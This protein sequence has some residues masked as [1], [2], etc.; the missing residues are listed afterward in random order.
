MLRNSK[1][2]PRGGKNRGTMRYRPNGLRASDPPMTD[3]QRS[4][5]GCRVQRPDQLWAMV[6][7]D[8]VRCDQLDVEDWIEIEQAAESR[9]FFE[10][11]IQL[12]TENAAL[13]AEIE[14]L[15]AKNAVLK[16]QQSSPPAPQSLNETGYRD[17]VTISMATIQLRKI[18]NFFRRTR[19][20]F[21]LLDNFN[22]IIKNLCNFDSDEVEIEGCGS[23]LRKIFE[24]VMS[25]SAAE[26]SENSLTI[27]DL[28]FKF[29]GSR[30]EFE[31]FAE[32]VSLWIT[33]NKLNIPDTHFIIGVM[34]RFTARKTMLNGGIAEYEK[35]TIQVIDSAKK[36]VFMI[37][38]T[39]FDGSTV[40]PCDFTVNSFAVSP[41][42]GIFVKDPSPIR[43]NAKSD[44]LAVLR[45][46]NSRTTACMTRRNEWNYGDFSLN[47][48][49]RGFK[50]HQAGYQM[51]GSPILE[52]S[53]CPITL[54]ESLC[55][56]LTGCNCS[57]QKDKN[58]KPIPMQIVLSISNAIGIYD[59]RKRCPH[60]RGQ[61]ASFISL[62]EK[63][64]QELKDPLGFSKLLM[65]DP[66]QR[67]SKSELDLLKERAEKMS[68]GYK[69]TQFKDLS[70]ESEE[71]LK[72]LAQFSRRFM[73]AEERDEIERPLASQAIGGGG[74]DAPPL[75][76]QAIG[77]GGASA[78]ALASQAR[79]SGGADAPPLASQAIGGGGAS[80]PALA[81]QARGSGGASAPA[82][83]S[84]ARGSG[85]AQSLSSFLPVRSISS[86]APVRPG[87]GSSIRP[88][89]RNIPDDYPVWHSVILRGS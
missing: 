39:L 53:E 27:P 49:L 46:V 66:Q 2:P 89:P 82:L 28:D 16:S 36:E 22:Q 59:N 40:F 48:L 57:K 21:L 73:S 55:V 72:S 1:N 38:I 9:R 35:F 77:G 86:A 71:V 37:D 51:L 15:K 23:V 24:I 43:R 12:K 81:S 88:P 84:Q 80:A 69:F 17:A 34:R 78:P 50:M 18:G 3:R 10:E 7:N 87:I 30:A 11:N 4:D 54:G 76:S 79:G 41:T 56:K 74:A 52:V 62:P 75:A 25:T 29:Y 13:K 33:T 68:N 61:L 8:D 60:C 83:A 70:P 44:F 65:S 26:V 47:F 20:F 58:G 31:E 19:L 5:F 45:D 32:K 85:S 63:S 67:V 42:Q 14:A 64:K 6:M